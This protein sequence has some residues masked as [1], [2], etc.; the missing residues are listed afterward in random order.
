[1]ARI[2]LTP[3]TLLCSRWIISILF[4]CLINKMHNSKVQMTMSNDTN[5]HVIRI[6]HIMILPNSHFR[7]HVRFQTKELDTKILYHVMQNTI[8]IGKILPFQLNSCI[9]EIVKPFLCTVAQRLILQL[10][11]VVSP[12]FERPPAFA[13]LDPV[14]VSGFPDAQD[15]DDGIGVSCSKTPY[16]W[17]QS[18][19]SFGEVIKHDDIHVLMLRVGG[20][21]LHQGLQTRRNVPGT[22]QAVSNVSYSACDLTGVAA[23][24]DE[25]GVG[26]HL[27]VMTV[28]KNGRGMPEHHV[29]QVMHQIQ[30]WIS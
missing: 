5:M 12:I 8:T 17:V 30:R 24:R 23:V 22:R 1:M 10:R 27:T 15:Y 7:I 29:P 3:C 14:Y 16:E 20:V 19:G 2:T 25:C 4:Y 9:V 6:K 21:L 28:F 11:H 13:V 18:I 26:V